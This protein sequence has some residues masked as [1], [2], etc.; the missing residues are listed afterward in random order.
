MYAYVRETFLFNWPLLK[1]H[2]NS[3]SKSGVCWLVWF[4][5]LVTSL[6]DLA[7]VLRNWASVRV[8]VESMQ[9]KQE[10]MQRKPS[11]G[12]KT[13]IFA[14]LLRRRRFLIRVKWSVANMF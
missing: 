13:K 8:E 14:I 5:D 7:M 4:L 6:C 11:M 3:S 9:T 12:W 10:N 2:R 1:K